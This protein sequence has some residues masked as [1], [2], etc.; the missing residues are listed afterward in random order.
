M[1]LVRLCLSSLLLLA[2]ITTGSLVVA[3]DDSTTTLPT[4]LRELLLST[5]YPSQIIGIGEAV[6]LGLNLYTDTEPQIAELELEGLPENW[7]ATFRGGGRI[8]ESVFV[9][10]EEEAKVDLRVEVPADVEPGTYPFTILA[11][12]N[13]VESELPVAFTVEAKAPAS[14]GVTTDLPNVRGK[15]STTFRYNI[16]LNNDGDEDLTVD[17]QAA[18]PPFFNVVFK[19]GSQEVT[20]IPVKANST[21]RISVEASPLLNNI[22]AGSYPITVTAKGGDLEA[23]AELM[24]EVVGQS[25]I[26][27]TTMDGRLS[28]EAEIGADTT[29]TLVLQNSGSAAARGV[30]L[31]ASQPSGWNV[32]FTPAEI[33]QI[34]PGQQ[35][36][37]TA[38]IRPSDK[39]LAGDY[40]VTFRAQPEGSTSESA[41]YR[42]TVRTSTLWGIAGV[43]L[44]AVAVGVVGFA[45]SRFG[46]R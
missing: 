29:L 35:A 12:A 25:D 39:A 19:S 36:E 4:R 38:K 20:N 42:I 7:N 10:P 21:E 30:K 3:Q 26:T 44:I 14:L 41:E 45:V 24:A 15:P 31:T 32:E 43:G 6:T 13:G 2:L 9:Q 34:E 8:V 18:A 1:T 46:R 5:D 17:L 37:V 11:H 33:E 22:A 23:T 27:L 28:G 16:T 40:M